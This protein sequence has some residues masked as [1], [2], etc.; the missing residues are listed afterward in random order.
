MASI[1]SYKAIISKWLD[2][3][4]NIGF[5][6]DSRERNL[7]QDILNLWQTPCIQHPYSPNQYKEFISNLFN[8]TIDANIEKENTHSLYSGHILLVEDNKINQLVAGD[9]LESLGI[10][11][12]LAED[13][14]QAI[15]LVSKNSSYDLILMDIQMPVVDGYTATKRIRELGYNDLRICGLSAN[16]LKEDLQKA[17]AVGMDDYLTKPLE[18]D[19]LETMIEK[20]LPLSEVNH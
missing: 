15:D 17:E 2:E 4:I 8:E 12:D 1:A 5:L 6:L 14:Q 13:G 3:G 9:M 11:Y 18:L 20:Y 16:S 7:R 10:T 19:M